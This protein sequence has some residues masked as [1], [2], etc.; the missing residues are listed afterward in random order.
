M[1]PHRAWLALGSA[2]CLLAGGSRA[3]GGDRPAAWTPALMMKV[4]RIGTV[5]VSPDGRQAAFT[6]R[7]AVLGGDKSEYRTH[8]HLAGTA[9][10]RS[11]QLTQGDRSCDD[12]QWSPDGRWLAFVSRRSGRKNV[13]LIRPDGGEARRLTDVKTGV[14]SFRWSPDGK[15][16]AF[17]AP[18][19]RTA[20][21][22]KAARERNDARVA[23]ENVK[24]NRLYV[25]PFTTPPKRQ[26]ARLLTKGNFSVGG[27]GRGGQ[28]AFDWSPDGKTIV[29]SHTRTPAPNDWTSADLSLVDVARATVK[30]LASTRAAE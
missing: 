2:L 18:D 20:E 8:I 17:T 22:E 9:G 15:W 23:D 3:G 19:G 27:A 26:E 5:R 6:V 7:R 28:A 25:I 29:F 13:W 12:P 14:A 11:A 16:L 24:M 4:K 30:P 10:G 21:E 1:P